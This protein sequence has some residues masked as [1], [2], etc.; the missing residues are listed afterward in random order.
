MA[1]RL[2]VS[3]LLVLQLRAKKHSVAQIAAA[4]H[5][6]EGAVTTA[7]AG[8]VEALDAQD[9]REAIA[10]ARRRGLITA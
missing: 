10:I 3:E 2:T 9:A 1:R 6:S 7:I 8:A 4:T 5:R